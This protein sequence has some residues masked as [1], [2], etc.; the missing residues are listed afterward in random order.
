MAICPIF[1]DEFWL[2]NVSQMLI[3]MVNLMYI[4]YCALS[5]NEIGVLLRI[6]GAM[7]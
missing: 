5:L 1:S 2:L 3:A 7:A 4:L 6:F